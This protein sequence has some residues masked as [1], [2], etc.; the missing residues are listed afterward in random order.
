MRFDDTEIGGYEPGAAEIK[1]SCPSC[2]GNLFL[3]QARVFLG[4]MKQEM[5]LGQI[6]H[7]QRHYNMRP[8]IY[9]TTLGNLIASGGFDGLDLKTYLPGAADANQMVK[10]EVYPWIRVSSIRDEDYG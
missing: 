2:F 8:I 3:G 1:I 6:R 4:N 7:M 9:E 10:V 5:Q